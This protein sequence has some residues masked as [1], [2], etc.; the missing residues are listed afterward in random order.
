MEFG[1]S[2]G[3]LSIISIAC[4]Q[5]LA[6]SSQSSF[7]SAFFAEYAA[8]EAFSNP[9]SKIFE[10]MDGEGIGEGVETALAS[11]MG[12]GD[13]EGDDEASGFQLPEQPTKNND[14]NVGTRSLHRFNIN[15]SELSAYIKTS[16]HDRKNRMISMKKR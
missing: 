11:K 10:G 16:L 4:C 15:R 13:G 3:K 7:I 6:V 2:I 14:E 12:E 5:R 1:W 8:L 9:I